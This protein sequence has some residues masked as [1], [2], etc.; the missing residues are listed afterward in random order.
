MSIGLKMAEQKEEWAQNALDVTTGDRLQVRD[1][2]ILELEQRGLGLSLECFEF[3]HYSWS[4]FH[5]K[6]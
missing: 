5:G 3:I 6:S 2:V 4:S 1:Y